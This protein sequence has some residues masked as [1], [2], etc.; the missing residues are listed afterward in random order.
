MTQHGWPCDAVFLAL[1]LALAPAAAAG[2]SLGDVGAREVSERLAEH[3]RLRVATARNYGRVPSAP[4]AAHH[5]AGNLGTKVHRAAVVARRIGNLLGQ[6]NRLVDGRIVER[7][8]GKR[9]GGG[10]GVERE[11]ETAA[12]HAN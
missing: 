4:K 10:L 9:G 5:D 11:G 1:A 2:C 7:G 3:E 8:S 6:P 12:K